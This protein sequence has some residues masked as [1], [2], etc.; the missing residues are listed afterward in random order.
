MLNALNLVGI[1]RCQKGLLNKNCV[2]CFHVEI[3]FF[4]LIANLCVFWA[5]VGEYINENVHNIYEQ[6]SSCHNGMQMHHHGWLVHKSLLNFL[7]FFKRPEAMNFDKIWIYIKLHF[8]VPLSQTDFATSDPKLRQA[9]TL[10]YNIRADF[11]KHIAHFL[12]A[13]MQMAYDRSWLGIKS[14]W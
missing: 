10:P 5:T 4:L 9:F 8:I 1:L 7:V 14:S 2:L 3:A 13:L 6:I 11:V 12:C